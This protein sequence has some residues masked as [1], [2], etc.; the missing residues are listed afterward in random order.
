MRA[1]R[2]ERR[3]DASDVEW[4][5]IELRNRMDWHRYE[6]DATC[7]WVRLVIDRTCGY[8]SKISTK[9]DVRE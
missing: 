4:S 5:G 9:A 3:M 6:T 2:T 7:R 8:M 1:G